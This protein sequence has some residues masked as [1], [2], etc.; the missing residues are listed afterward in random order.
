MIRSITLKFGPQAAAMPMAF[1][2][3]PLNVFVGPNNSGKSLILREVE[4]E[5]NLAVAPTKHILE[6]IEPQRF[7]IE[8][9]KAL[10]TSRQVA[11]PTA[12]STGV[13]RLAK[14]NP[15]QQGEDPKV[16]NLEQV[17]HQIKT[18]PEARSTLG[19]LVWLF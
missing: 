9:V 3:A 2:V 8:E 14:I 11:S 16:I 4:Y 7:T 18:N 6:R 10:L 12:L 13:V 1:S 15:V 5:M 17:L 19:I